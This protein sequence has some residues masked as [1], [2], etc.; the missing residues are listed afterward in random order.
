[1]K[2]DI[3]SY[4]WYHPPQQFNSPDGTLIQRG[5]GTGPAKPRQPSGE[6]IRDWY[7]K[8]LF[9]NQR[10]ANSGRRMFWKMRG[11]TPQCELPFHVPEGAISFLSEVDHERHFYDF[12]QP[13]VHI[14]IGNRG[15][16]GQALRPDQRRG[17]GCLPGARP[18]LTRGLRDGYQDRIRRAAGRDHYSSR[19]QLRYSGAQGDQRYR[20]R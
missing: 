4:P 20:L 2:I 14:G 5:G 6:E 16:S 10:G 19:H 11:R 13:D 1:M 9:F 8:S 18:S 7:D 12:T 17:V 15:A 3:P